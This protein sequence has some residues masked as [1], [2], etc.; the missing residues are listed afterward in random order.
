M[1]GQGHQHRQD[2]QD[3]TGSFPI[4]EARHRPTTTVVETIERKK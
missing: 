2:R 4:T 1:E 3:R